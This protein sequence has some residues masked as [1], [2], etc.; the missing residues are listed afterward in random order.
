[1]ILE[2]EHGG[3][4]VTKEEIEDDQQRR[5]KTRESYLLGRDK[6]YWLKFIKDGE[7]DR[8]AILSKKYRIDQI[9]FIQAE[10]LRR[11]WLPN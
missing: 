9:E 5:K 2:A 10:M 4:K 7:L 11:K 6:S 3:Y 8:V 1:M